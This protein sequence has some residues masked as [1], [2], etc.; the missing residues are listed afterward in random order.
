MTRQLGTAKKLNCFR[1]HIPMKW[2][3]YNNGDVG[4]ECPEHFCH[5][6]VEFPANGYAVLHDPFGDIMASWSKDELD[7]HYREII[8]ER[9]FN[10]IISRHPYIDQ[11]ETEI[12]PQGHKL[13]DQMA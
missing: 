8:N 2:V 1:C 13:G 3:E 10:K 4:L 5:I 6:R 7:A 12:L 11:E 9:P